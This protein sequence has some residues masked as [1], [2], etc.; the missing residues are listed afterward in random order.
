MEMETFRLPTEQELKRFLE[1]NNLAPMVIKNTENI[2]LISNED[3]GTV[4]LTF[5]TADSNNI[6]HHG[7]ISYRI[8]GRIRPVEALLS[9]QYCLTVLLIVFN[10]EEIIEK[11][12]KILAQNINGEN[13]IVHTKNQKHIIIVTDCLFDLEKKVFHLGDI[14]IYDNNDIMIYRKKL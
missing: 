11:A 14:F 1:L 8:K 10:N 12:H 4:R 7:K 6:T 13:V 2:T 9:S 5:L 3:F